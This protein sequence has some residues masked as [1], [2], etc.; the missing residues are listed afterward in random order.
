MQVSIFH[1]RRKS[2]FIYPC[3]STWNM[4][5]NIEI[6]LG[7]GVNAKT[8]YAKLMSKHVLNDRSSLGLFC[9]YDPSGDITYVSWQWMYMYLGFRKE[10]LYNGFMIRRILKWFSYAP[11]KK[12]VMYRIRNKDTC[13]C[14][15]NTSYEVPAFMSLCH[16]WAKYILIS[17]NG[18]AKDVG[19]SVGRL[20]LM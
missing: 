5:E 13:Q 8:W 12:L 1:L 7:L 2:L 9:D 16:M 14:K 11:A 17:V 20:Q 3:K 15:Y 6:W 4:I 18:Y 10:V 19:L